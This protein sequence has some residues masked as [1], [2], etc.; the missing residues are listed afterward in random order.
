VPWSDPRFAAMLLGRAFETAGRT[1]LSPWLCGGFSGMALA[2]SRVGRLIGLELDAELDAVDAVLPIVLRTPRGYELLTGVCGIGLYLVERLPRPYTTHLLARVTQYLRE[3]SER[4]RV[5]RFWPA[6]D[7]ARRNHYRLGMAHG[8][9]GVVA[10][11]A[12][13][14]HVGRRDAAAVELLDEAVRGLLAHRSSSVADPSCFP[15]IVQPGRYGRGN[16]LTWCWGDLGIALALAAAGRATANAEW[17]GVAVVVAEEAASFRPNVKLACLCHGTAGIAHQFR[18]MFDLTARDAF[19]E[20]ALYWYERT[21]DL[22]D[23]GTD[24][25]VPAR[26]VGTSLVLSGAIG[27]GLALLAAVSAHEPMW[28]FMLLGD[29]SP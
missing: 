23:Q 21:L 10:F 2:A 1:T 13:F 9:A 27:V 12:T 14:I 15:D 28:D 4:S 5:G 3:S 19:R 26:T 22:C 18:R 7:G 16:R 8:A 11:L 6:G 24:V 20:A 29:V 25:A 17:T